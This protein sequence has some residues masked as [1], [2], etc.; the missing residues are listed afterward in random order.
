MAFKLCKKGNCGVTITDLNEYQI[1]SYLTRSS[2]IYYTFMQSASIN[3]LSS[4]ND[5][6]ESTLQ[7]YKNTYLYSSKFI[8]DIL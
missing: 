3:T 1:Q 5:E 2:T 8:I 6:G 4:S 7:A